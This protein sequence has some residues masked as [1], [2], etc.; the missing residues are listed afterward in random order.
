VLG[1]DVVVLQGRR[2]VE[3]RGE[4]AG[5][6][7]A[8]G[9]LLHGRAGGR[10]Q[11]AEDL[12]GAGG[13]RADVDAGLGH[14]AAGG[15]LLLAQQRHEQVD[16]LGGGVAT[17]GRGELGSLD[18]LAAA[19]RELLGTELAQLRSFPRMSSSL[20]AGATPLWRHL[21]QRARS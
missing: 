13:Q 7:G 3:R 17:G 19:G 4:D 11:R 2:Q 14:H 15:A 6:R 1:G 8:R 20:G 21:S 5:Q 18:H 9:G 10:R 16:R 12:L